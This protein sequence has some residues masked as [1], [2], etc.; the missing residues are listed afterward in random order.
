[1]VL[2][3]KVFNIHRRPHRRRQAD[4]SVILDFLTASSSLSSLRAVTET[5][6]RY[7]H[8]VQ[9][10]YRITDLRAFLCCPPLLPWSNQPRL[11]TKFDKAYLALLAVVRVVLL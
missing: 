1:V 9:S 3:F 10:N 6:I 7:L 4:R 11:N 5:V 2:L 8:R